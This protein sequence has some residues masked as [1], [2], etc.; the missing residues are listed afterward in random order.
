VLFFNFFALRMMLRHSPYHSFHLF[1]HSDHFLPSSVIHPPSHKITQWTMP[2]Q[3][4]G[5]WFKHSCGLSDNQRKGARLDAWSSMVNGL[6]QRGLVS[7]AIRVKIA[8]TTKKYFRMEGKKTLFLRPFWISVS[9]E[10]RTNTLKYYYG[11]VRVC[12]WREHQREMNSFQ[13]IEMK[14]IGQRESVTQIGLPPPRI[15]RVWCLGKW[16]CVMMM[17]RSVDVWWWAVMYYHK[18]KWRWSVMMRD[19]E[20]SCFVRSGDELWWGVTSGDEWW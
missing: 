18:E 16:W 9:W 1:S 13:E 3:R 10:E 19:V 17:G 20:W 4:R 6:V 11:E 14:G 2:K 15:K 8:K 5:M 12:H 7:M